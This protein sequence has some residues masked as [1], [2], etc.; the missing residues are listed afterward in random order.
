[1]G[2]TAHGPALRACNINDSH[3]ALLRAL[4]HATA[5]PCDALACA[6]Y[7]SLT[8][9]THSRV[10]GAQPAGGAGG[11]A[12]PGRRADPARRSAAHVTAGGAGQR[13]S[14]LLLLRCVVFRGPGKC[15]GVWSAAVHAA[16]RC[17]CSTHTLTSAAHSASPDACMQ[18]FFVHVL[19]YAAHTLCAAHARWRAQTHG[20]LWRGV[21]LGP[22]S[23]AGAGHPQQHRQEGAGAAAAAARGR[24]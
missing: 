5:L 13:A 9:T 15:E 22:D 8:N 4:A 18:P 20:R 16:G 1:V 14:R 17:T 21:L 11:S 7:A 12:D 23:Q 2:C 6:P 3:Q 19:T 10:P 24:G